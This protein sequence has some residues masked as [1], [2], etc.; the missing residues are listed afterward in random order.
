VNLDKSQLGRVHEVLLRSFDRDELRIMLRLQL[1]E[2]LDTVAGD[3]DFRTVV[4]NL[5]TWAERTNRMGDLVAGALAANPTNGDLQ[6]LAADFARWQ[7]SAAAPDSALPLP[8]EKQGRSLMVALGLGGVAV[9]ALLVFLLLRPLIWGPAPVE[10]TPIAPTPS[11]P[12][13]PTVD[14]PLAEASHLP[15]TPLPTAAPPQDTSPQETPTI[16]LTEPVPAPTPSATAT[17]DSTAT[18]GATATPNATATQVQPPRAPALTGARKYTIF[19]EDNQLITIGSGK[20]VPLDMR[21]LWSAPAG[22]PATCAESF[23]LVSW[24]VRQPYPGG[25]ELEVRRVIPRGGGQTEL[26]RTGA[27]GRVDLGYCDSVILRNPDLVDYR[28]EWRFVSAIPTP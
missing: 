13:L 23:V 28:L 14:S 26:L 9:A 1:G 3:D 2:D 6:Q 8:V 18:P 25:E 24:Q 15:V 7:Q 21:D 16:G 5:V 11:E 12:A 4:F 10:P 20:A 19:D 27:R 17:P 22:T